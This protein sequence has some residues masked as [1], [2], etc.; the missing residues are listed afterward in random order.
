[1]YLAQNNEETHLSFKNSEKQRTEA[2]KMATINSGLS[3]L[4][5]IIIFF[6]IDLLE[7]KTDF[8]FYTGPIAITYLCH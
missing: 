8:D 6:L 5:M 4:N 1:M 2:L 3:I 7:K